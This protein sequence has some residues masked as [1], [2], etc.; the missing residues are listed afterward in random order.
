MHPLL[1][2]SYAGPA[3]RIERTY[4]CMDLF[5]A[6]VTVI[7]FGVNVIPWCRPRHDTSGPFAF[8]AT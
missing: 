3:R 2:Q 8:R 1:I 7:Y 4:R 6:N 5:S